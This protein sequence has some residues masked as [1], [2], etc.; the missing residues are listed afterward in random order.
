MLAVMQ[1]LS[2]TPE[3]ATQ[4]PGC[5]LF[6][7]PAITTDAVIHHKILTIL[8]CMQALNAVSE[9]RHDQSAS[10]TQHPRTTSSASLPAVAK[11]ARSSVGPQQDAPATKGS[12]DS[13]PGLTETTSHDAGRR[14]IEVRLRLCVVTN[15]LCR[16]V[17]FTC[18]CSCVDVSF[19][20]VR[21]VQALC[22]LLLKVSTST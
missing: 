3:M 12:S 15:P 4:H 17:V 10:R 21:T 1:A 19:S 14:Q 11:G 7:P 8:S 18:V 2:I 20:F 16:L 13:E 6:P 5:N 9:G 22:V